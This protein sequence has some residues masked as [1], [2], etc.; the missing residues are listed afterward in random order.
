MILLNAGDALIGGEHFHEGHIRT[1]IMDHTQENQKCS[2]DSS[3]EGEAEGA[4]IQIRTTAED[5]GETEDRCED[6][7]G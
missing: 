6:V 4:K 3:P 1:L 2:E 7:P 5:Q